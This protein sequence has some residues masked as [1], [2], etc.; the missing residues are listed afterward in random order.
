[1][2]KSTLF[3]IAVLLCTCIKPAISQVV[4]VVNK[5]NPASNIALADLKKQYL[6]KVETWENGKKVTLVQKKSSAESTVLFYKTV[7]G[8][9][10]KKMKSYWMKKMLGGG[11]IGPK[12]LGSDEEV[13]ELVASNDGAIAFIDASNLDDSIKV[14][15]IEGV[16]HTDEN[17]L[18]GK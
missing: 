6:G 3:V 12:V 1:M 13:K 2:K 4:V 16:S 18:L 10:P 14:L 9:T 8:K 11:A 5:N 15:T 7:V 17:Y